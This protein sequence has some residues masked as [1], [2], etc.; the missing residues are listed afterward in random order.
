MTR[1]PLVLAVAALLAACDQAAAPTDPNA[2]RV[3]TPSLQAASVTQKFSLDTT[4][5]AFVDCA[6]EELEFHLTEQL[7]THQTVDAAGRL[8]THF[9]INDQG[10]TAVGQT[11]GRVWH[12]TGATTDNLNIT[13]SI[14]GNE[15]A[16]NS[17]N[18]VG[19]GR[20]PNLLVH[21]IFHITV[22]PRGV[23]TVLFNKARV[24]C[25]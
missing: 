24:V 16:A 12:Q 11:T 19:Q 5:V 25:R 10:S 13:P 7:V 9:T 4:F 2:G 22:N 1:L 23:I 18:L 14:T 17:L 6:G 8:H 15:T 20:A 3:V 21:T